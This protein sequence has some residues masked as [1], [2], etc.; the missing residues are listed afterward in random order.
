MKRRTLPSPSRAPRLRAPAGPRRDSS[1]STRTASCLRATSALSSV[2]PSSTAMISKSPPAAK[3][4]LR[5]WDR[6]S[7]PLC[8]GM[9]TE[10]YGSLPELTALGNRSDIS[11]LRLRR[12][13]SQLRDPLGNKRLGRGEPFVL[14]HSFHFDSFFDVLRFRID[15]PQIVACAEDVFDGQH[16]RQHRVILIVVFVHAVAPDQ[17]QVND[18]AEKAAN[19]LQRLLIGKVIN[20]VSLGDSDDHGVLHL[21]GFHQTDLFHLALAQFDQLSV[22]HRPQPVTLETEILKAETG[23]LGVCDH[24]RAPVLEVLNAPHLHFGVMYIDP[25]I[26]EYIAAIDDQ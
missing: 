2:E 24:V 3:S 4:A 26:G 13:S 1:C 5:H 12:G 19:D 17:L 18:R 21:T 7:P 20:R 6:C 22:C 8:T 9:M 14:F 10:M 15:R 25:V 16:R 23:L 11:N